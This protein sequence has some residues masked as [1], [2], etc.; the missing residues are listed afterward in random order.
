MRRRLEGGF[1][2]HGLSRAGHR[3]LL[4]ELAEEAHAAVAAAIAGQGGV[5]ADRSPIDSLAFWLHFGFAHEPEERTA[6][7]VATLLERCRQ[8]D[9][10]LLLPWGVLPLQD[11]GIRS[12]NRWLQLKFHALVEGLA[13]ELLPAAQLALLPKERVA[14]QDR[15]AWV[16]A[17]LNVLP[18][19]ISI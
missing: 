3:A 10:V 6:A 18:E 5:V 9:L 1:D 17:K 16:E 11:D 15:I 12:A 19:S 4:L 13:R 2:P 14:P 8:F 7:L